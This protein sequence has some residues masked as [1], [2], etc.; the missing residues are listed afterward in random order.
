MHSWMVEEKRTNLAMKSAVGGIP[1]RANTK[2]VIK[3]ADI[4]IF[5]QEL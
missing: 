4:G 2:I 1:A 3:R 5:F